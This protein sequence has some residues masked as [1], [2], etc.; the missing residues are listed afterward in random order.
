MSIPFLGHTVYRVV[1]TNN[2][3]IY[4]HLLSCL[5]VTIS[6]GYCRIFTLR[7]VPKDP[8]NPEE[9]VIVIRSL[10]PGGVAE[11][12]GRLIPGDRLVAVNGTNL[13]NASLDQAVAALKGAPKG[14][15][16][17]SVA[18]PISVL[19][20]PGKVST[21]GDDGEGSIEDGHKSRKKSSKQRRITGVSGSASDYESYTTR[22]DLEVH[23]SKQD[24]IDDYDYV[25]ETKNRSRND[26]HSSYRGGSSD[27]YISAPSVY[28]GYGDGNVVRSIDGVTP[29]F[30]AKYVTTHDPEQPTAVTGSTRQL[31]KNQIINLNANDYQDNILEQSNNYTFYSGN[32]NSA[33]GIHHDPNNY[34]EEVQGTGREYSA[35]Y[36]YGNRMVRG[37]GA[38]G[39][40]IEQHQEKQPR[41]VVDPSNL[42]DDHHYQNQQHTS[43]RF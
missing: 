23:K 34:S 25:L 17:I 14:P 3:V 26:T 43:S 38:A 19:E 40:A 32:S 33:Q 31:F 13:E 2:F 5:P 18:K 12:D 16:Q 28:S 8:L 7:P 30:T 42:H 20:S 41:G 21:T 11:K 39:M 29:S 22:R 27:A 1:T 35:Y 10:V 24:A 37:L 6:L 9:T 36:E 4:N 15:V